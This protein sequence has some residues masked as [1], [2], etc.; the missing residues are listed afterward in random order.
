MHM[1]GVVATILWI[2]TA[3][4]Q[5]MISGI[6]MLLASPFV[7]YPFAWT[8]HALFENNKPLA[9]TNPLWA[10]VADLRMCWE[11]VTGKLHL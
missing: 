8:S 4:N 3:L 9:F 6:L 2:I 10:K 7:V 11:V 5:P 1:A